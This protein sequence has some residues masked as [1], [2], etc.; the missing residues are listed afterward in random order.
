MIAS[1]DS[2]QFHLRQALRQCVDLLGERIARLGL[3]GDLRAIA[4]DRNRVLVVNGK[5]RVQQCIAIAGAV[6][7]W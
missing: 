2:Q 7:E 6:Q 5:E 4:L 3:A 1:T